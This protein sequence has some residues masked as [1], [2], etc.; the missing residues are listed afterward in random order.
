MKKALLLSLL[1][2]TAQAQKLKPITLKG[3]KGARVDGKPWSSNELKEKVH[4]LFYVD[5]DEKDLN[6]HVSQALKKEKFNLDTY[7]SVAVINMAATWKPNFAIQ[8]ALEEKQEE[9]PDT[10]YVKDMEKILVNE[11]KLK[12]DSSN[13]LLFSK[14]GEMVYKIL[15]KATKKQVEELIEQIRHELKK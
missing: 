1:L 12:D 6:D 13:V 10:I 2:L 7:G 11:W 5:P 14:D 8:S 4:V 15:G 3:D 9:F